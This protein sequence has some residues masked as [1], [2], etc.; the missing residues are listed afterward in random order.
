[1]CM[2]FSSSVCPAN[3]TDLVFVYDSVAIGLRKGKLLRKTLIKILR[4]IDMNSTSTRVGVVSS[5]HNVDTDFKLKDFN[6]QKSLIRKM[7]RPSHSGMSKLLSRL[8]HHSFSTAQGGRKDA[9]KVAVIF[10]D[11]SVHDV[12]D[13][14]GEIK[15]AS[16]NFRVILVTVDRHQKHKSAEICAINNDCMRVQNY[17]SLLKA[18]QKILRLIC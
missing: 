7:R 18:S 4:D 15:R 12:R 3:P 5:Y 16:Y 6:V 14:D 2:H 13:I 9:A 10:L 17:H 1:M 8:R 11:K